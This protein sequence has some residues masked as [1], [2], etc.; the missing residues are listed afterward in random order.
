M[1][2]SYERKGKDLNES[3]TFNLDESLF[4][5]YIVAI[6]FMGLVKISNKQN[7]FRNKN[8]IFAT[9]MAHKISERYYFILDRFLHL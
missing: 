7:Y 4:N 1:K 6:L 5:R 2:A 3:Y 9:Q 8:S